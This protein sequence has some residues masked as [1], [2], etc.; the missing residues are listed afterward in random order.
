MF[1]VYYVQNS[2]KNNDPAITQ[3]LEDTW[4]RGNVKLRN[5]SCVS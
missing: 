5:L 4:S 2:G 3:T 1:F